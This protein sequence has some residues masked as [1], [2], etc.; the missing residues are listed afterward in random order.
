MGFRLMILMVMGLGAMYMLHLLAQDWDKIRQPLPPRV[1]RLLTSASIG[2]NNYLTRGRRDLNNLRRIPRLSQQQQYAMKINSTENV[3]D[4]K[5]ILSRDPLECLQ[6]LVCQLMS[7]AET[8]SQESVMICDF[9]EENISIAPAK[10][11]RAF[12]RGLA[13]RG[14]TERCYDEYPFCWYSAKTM[15]RIL[16]W[17]ADTVNNESGT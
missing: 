16:K 10:I 9:L 7:G 5:R 13:F 8:N 1:S 6:S 3:I 2:L 12:S 15:M 14:Q 17:F 4:W 11:G